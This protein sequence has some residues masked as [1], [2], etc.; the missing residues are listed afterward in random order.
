MSLVGD[1]SSRGV[2][3][4]DKRGAVGGGGLADAQLLGALPHHGREMA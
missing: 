2:S 3:S 1:V 4:H